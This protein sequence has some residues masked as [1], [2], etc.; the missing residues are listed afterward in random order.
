MVLKTPWQIIGVLDRLFK[1]MKSAKG[2]A[3]QQKLPI[4]VFQNLAFEFSV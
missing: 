3:V 2:D 1:G 4:T